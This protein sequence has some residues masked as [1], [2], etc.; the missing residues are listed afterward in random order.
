[1]K[2]W[3]LGLMFLILPCVHGREEDIR[4]GC[5]TA[6]IDLVYIMD[7]SSSV[8]APD[9]AAA[10]RWLVNVTAG[11]GV[12]PRRARVGVVQYSDTPRLEVP[13]GRHGSA[14][15]LVRAIHAVAHLGGSTR[16][17]RAIRF[18]VE[19]VFPAP[20]GARRRAAVV[21]TDGRSQDDVVDAA[22]EAR[23][24]N[25]VLFAVGVGREVTS[26][27]LESMASRPAS[28]HVLHAEDYTTIHR[29]RDAMEQKLC[30][31]SVCPLWIPMGSRD[32]KGFDLILAME[33][34]GK[35]Q[36]VQGSLVSEAAYLFS[37]GMD[38]TMDTRIIFPEGLPPAYVFVATLR[39]RAPAN[40]GR[41]H[42]LRVLSEAGFAQVAVT[43]SGDDR[44]VTFTTTSV[45]EEEQSVIF[46]DR[47][48]KRLF[49]E[50]W[51]QLKLL[52]KPRRVTCFLDGVQIEEQLLE[53]TVPI[54][55]NGQ[56]Q[57]A[58]DTRAGTTVAIEIQ[59]LRLYCDPQQSERE[60]A[61]EIYSVHDDR[62]PLDRS[63]GTGECHC[64][65]GSPGPPGLPGPMGDAGQPGT[66][67][68][69]GQRGSKGD[70]GERG[71]PGRAGPPGPT[72]SQ[73]DPGMPGSPGQPGARGVPGT[74]G[75]DGPA[76]PMGAKGDRGEPGLPGVDGQSGVPGI[77][78]LPGQMG[79]VGSQGERGLPGMMG[80][81]G[82]KGPQGLHG[83]SGAPG[84]DGPQGPKGNSGEKGP[85]GIPGQP[86]L[87]GNEGPPG[88]RGLP[89]PM[90][91]PGFK[92][93]KGELGPQ[94]PKGNQGE[95]GA[96]GTP[97]RHGT[98]GE[99][100]L[101]GGKGEKGVVGDPGVRGA[102]GKKG[103]AGFLG[104]VGSPGSPGRDGLPGQ[105]G[106]PGYP[107]KP[108]KPPTDEHLL[109]LCSTVLQN[110]LPELLRAMAPRG[111]RHCE[112]K[113]GPAGEPGPPG[114]TG[115]PG[116]VGY[117]GTTG[118][119]G[120]P[121]PPGRQGLQ[122]IKGEM[123]PTGVKGSKGEGDTGSPGLPGPTGIPGPPG[124]DG[125]GHRGPPGIPGQSG[126]PGVP[127][128][129][130]P[131]GPA[132]VCDVSSC[133]QAY[134]YRHDRFSKGPNS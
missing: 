71:V 26:S 123:G 85:A 24:Q 92:G 110:Q 128:K 126:I 10:K 3:R 134:G 113:P 130:G 98:P 15:E 88:P 48:I 40:R 41:L 125:V 76:G 55:I 38:V 12:G 82:P 7:G 95:R 33:I 49:D 80:L 70:R 61:C 127:G 116:P 18:A 56:T 13:L 30:E 79:P 34:P 1:M 87:G 90:G 66:K 59:K 67:G 29:I 83:P 44:S 2:S 50:D 122:G 25:I 39:L 111:C 112:T 31:E 109:K 101:R 77:R 45:H 51:H 131:A 115:P 133:Y 11:L 118:S 73:G 20:P 103:D 107:G 5:S 36:K 22:L 32:E 102:D 6:A 9:F 105:P 37:P 99:P 124:T 58:T 8:G 46:N 69:S 106:V 57:V 14:A 23:S 86:G 35:A 65:I 117:P 104:A 47:G 54:Y 121:G 53:R 78:G 119:R 94:G 120:Y 114:P 129:R 91:M 21:V 62:C 84:L 74:L 75:D 17:G 72:G 89:G 4:A 68:Q 42:L 60:T 132:G 19:H 63:L 96:N 16:T 64:P 52:V 81:T 108:G 43:L 100:G 93:H 97:G 28:A 27:E